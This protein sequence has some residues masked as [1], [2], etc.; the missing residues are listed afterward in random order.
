MRRFKKKWKLE[1][2]PI[3]IGQ[4]GQ[5]DLNDENNIAAPAAAAAPINGE[6]GYGVGI[7]VGPQAPFR[8]EREGFKSDGR[9]DRIERVGYVQAA[10]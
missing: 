3:R 10:D 2:V 6:H 8:E 7:G 4:Q 1:N 5:E 9:I